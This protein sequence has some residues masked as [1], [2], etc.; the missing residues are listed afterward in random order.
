[1]EVTNEV[2]E[3]HLLQK[4]IRVLEIPITTTDLPT[5]SDLP[6]MKLS[7]IYQT[8][9][10]FKKNLNLSDESLALLRLFMLLDAITSTFK[11]PVQV[12]TFVV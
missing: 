11:D 1:M 5:I 8:I 12:L 3:L 7:T 2:A 4:W 10:A 9:A 6:S